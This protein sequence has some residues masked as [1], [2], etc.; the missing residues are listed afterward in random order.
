MIINTT[1]IVKKEESASGGFPTWPTSV[2]D[3]MVPE[4]VR[5][6]AERFV[7]SNASTENTPYIKL[8]QLN[9]NPNRNYFTAIGSNRAVLVMYTQVN[10][11]AVIGEDDVVYL[12]GS[13]DEGEGIWADIP[14]NSFVYFTMTVNTIGSTKYGRLG[15]HTDTGVNVVQTISGIS[16]CDC[17]LDNL[18]GN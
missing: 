15:I 18:I 4:A 6:G 12:G 13:V 2:N 3:P 9:N 17:F 14:A 11:R 5:S 10:C 8:S 16:A 1:T 7:F